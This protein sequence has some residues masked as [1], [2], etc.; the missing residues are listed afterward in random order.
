MFGTNELEQCSKTKLER[1][2]ISELIDLQ[3]IQIDTSKP[4]AERIPEFLEQVRNPYLFKVGDVAMK[5]NYG[6]GKAFSDAI[7]ALLQ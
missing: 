1:S 7:A 6:D 3:S 5:V 4:V 2:D